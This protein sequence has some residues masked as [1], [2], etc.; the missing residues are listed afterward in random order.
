VRGVDSDRG[1]LPQL[2]P[3]ISMQDLAGILI[4]RA[5][6]QSIESGQPYA[7]ALG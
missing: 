3:C 7:L 4:R 1:N 6:K 2:A 5:W